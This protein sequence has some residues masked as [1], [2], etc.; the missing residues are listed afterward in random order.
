MQS[1]LPYSVDK[2]FG[3]YREIDSM[4]KIGEKRKKIG[5]DIEDTRWFW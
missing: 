4:K 2:R 1:W 5:P 3:F